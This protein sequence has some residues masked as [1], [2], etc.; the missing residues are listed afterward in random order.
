MIEGDDDELVHV[1]PPAR[2]TIAPMLERTPAAREGSPVA[3]AIV[4]NRRSNGAMFPDR[5]L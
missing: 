3:R 1:E 4:G 2:R 5:S